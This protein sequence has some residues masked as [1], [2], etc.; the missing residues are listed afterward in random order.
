MAATRSKIIAIGNSQ[1]VRLP[2]NILEQV[3]IAGANRAEIIGQEIELTPTPDGLLMRAV[4]HP[5][6][7][8]AEHFARMAEEGDDAL[9][10]AN[11]PVS[12]W[13]EQEW[14]W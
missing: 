4:H 3:G 6:A 2:V 12:G 9:L 13:D 8:W 10:D 1:G 14:T 5:R 7:G 11:L